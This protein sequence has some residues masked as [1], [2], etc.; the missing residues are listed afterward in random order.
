[1][2]LIKTELFIQEIHQSTPLYIYSPTD[3]PADVG[4]KINGVLTLHHGVFSL[5]EDWLTM[6]SAAR[7]AADNGYI[8]V[9]PQTDN[10]FCLDMLYGPRF[11]TGLTKYLPRY[12]KQMFNIPDDPRIN[13][14][15][16]ASAGGYVA[17]RTGMIYPE[18]YAAIGCF[19]GV[20]DTYYMMRFLS[21][22]RSTKP[23]ITAAVGDDLSTLPGSDKDLFHLSQEMLKRPADEQPDIFCTCGSRDEDIADLYD[24]NQR[25]RKFATENKMKYHYA[26]WDGSHDW[27]FWDRSLAEFFGFINNNDYGKCKTD[28]WAAPVT[29]HRFT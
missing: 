25:F 28:D 21:D 13:Y 6:T 4:N 8:L 19:S 15:A 10:S 27:N 16:G 9:I 23:L 3:L 29:T 5:G 12:L 1:M 22:F 2:A 26:E 11:F 7:Y 14:I 20:V 17:L 18:R 24:Q